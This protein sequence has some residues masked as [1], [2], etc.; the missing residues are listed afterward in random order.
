MRIK[1]AAT[2]TKIVAQALPDKAWIDQEVGDCHFKAVRLA[3]R[4]SKLLGMM[5]D[6]IGES[7]PYACQDWANTQAAYRLFSNAEVSRQRHLFFPI[8]KFSCR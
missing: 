2:R 1:K 7:V 3:K 8:G 5:S 6:G 4:F